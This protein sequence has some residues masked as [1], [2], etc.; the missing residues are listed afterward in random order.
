MNQ[1]AA[2]A[3]YIHIFLCLPLW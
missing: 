1:K 2:L 3:A